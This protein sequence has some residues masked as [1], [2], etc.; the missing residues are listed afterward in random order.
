MLAVWDYRWLLL[1]GTLVTIAVGIASLVIAI[2]LGLIGAWGKLSASR[3]AQRLAGGYTTLIRSIP[4]LCLMLLLYYGGQTLLNRAGEKTGLW[5][6]AEIDAFT[7]GVLTIG[8]IY[9]AYMTETFRGAYQ[10]IHKG[11]IEAASAYGMSRAL[12]FRRIVLPQ[13]LRYALPS[14]SNNWQVLLKTTALVSVLGLQEVVYQ[15]FVAGRTTK[16]LFAFFFATLV[17]Y[18]LLTALSDLVFQAL[19][20][21]FERGI[22]RAA[23]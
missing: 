19:R 17:I 22:R 1:E 15:A 6:H 7:A 10:A 14:L 4:D 9:G 3:A 8:F 2:L 16:Q 13:L 20:A 23:I 21:R 12:R 11:E 18:L 5:S